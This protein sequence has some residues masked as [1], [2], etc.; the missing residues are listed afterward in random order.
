MRYDIM[1]LKLNIDTVLKL[2][3]GFLDFSLKKSIKLTEIK[4]HKW[5]ELTSS[6][7]AINIFIFLKLIIDNFQ[8]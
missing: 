2:S 7:M 6:H 8:N 3:N 4:R 1:K 5:P